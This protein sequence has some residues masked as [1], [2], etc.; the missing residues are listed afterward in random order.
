MLGLGGFGL[1]APQAQPEVQLSP[2]SDVDGE[3]FQTL[4]MQLP[5]A[6]RVNK[7]VKSGWMINIQEI[8]SKMQE[9]NIFTMA[10]GIVGDEVKFYFHCKLADESGYGFGEIVFKQSMMSVS[11]VVKTTRGDLNE[12]MKVKFEKLLSAFTT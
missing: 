10:S 11:G 12:A 4:W 9:G 2:H 1:G 6:G 3:K 8:Q 5:E 7:Q